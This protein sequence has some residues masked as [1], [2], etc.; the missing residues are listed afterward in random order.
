MTWHNN[1]YITCFILTVMNDQKQ[2][3]KKKI[4]HNIINKQFILIGVIS[5]ESSYLIVVF[6]KF[7]I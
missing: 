4:R 5:N 2:E 3:N 7:P 1:Y 6:L